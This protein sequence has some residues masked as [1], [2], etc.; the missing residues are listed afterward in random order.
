MLR[1]GELECGLSDMNMDIEEGD[2]LFFLP[3]VGGKG[4]KENGVI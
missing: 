3:Q 2:I 1:S 4:Q